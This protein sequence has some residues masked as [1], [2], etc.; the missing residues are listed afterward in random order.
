MKRRASD[1]KGRWAR[2]LGPV[3]FA[4]ALGQA[5]WA[6]D[7]PTWAFEPA[8]D[9]YSD[10]A[11]LD[12]RHL[13]EE[14]AG[15]HG[16]VR[17]TPDGA[18]L[19]RGDGKPLRLW[20]IDSK[21]F[22]THVKRR[23]GEW[24]E[25]Y[26]AETLERHF[27][28]LAKRGINAVRI[29]GDISPTGSQPITEVNAREVEAIQRYVAVAKKHGIYVIL[30]PYW[31]KAKIPDGWEGALPGMYPG[32]RPWG[33]VFFD[34]AFQAAYRGWLRQL[35][36]GPNPHGPVLKDEPAIAV[37]QM[38]NE[39]SPLFPTFDKLPGA[40][41]LAIGRRFHAWAME[42]Y[43]DTEGIRKEWGRAK[44]KGD[45]WEGGV[46]GLYSVRALGSKPSGARRGPERRMRDQLE[47]IGESM[48]A[49]YAE[50]NR[51]LAEDLGCKQLTNGSNW[52]TASVTK[53]ND[54]ERWA[55]AGADVLAVNR[56][57]G[58]TGHIGWTRIKGR[59][60]KTQGWRV[61]PG[62]LVTFDSVLR[63]P[64]RLP[65]NLRHLA[66]T[67]MMI[68][69]SSWKHPARYQSEGPFLVAAYGSL[70]GL[71]AFTW[72]N[73]KVPEWHAD[74]RRKVFPVKEGERGYALDKWSAVVPQIAGAWPANAVIY[75]RGLV[76]E[77]AAVVREER[78][79][80]SLWERLPPPLPE[81]G[82]FDPNRDARPPKDEGLEVGEGQ[83]S[84]LAFLAGRVE[85]S[86][87]D[88]D[89]LEVQGLSDALSTPGRVRSVTGELELDY[90]RGFA[91]MDTPQAQGATGFWRDAG[92]EVALSTVTIRSANEYAAIQ[93]VA[94]DERPLAESRKVLV[95]FASTAR[96]TGWE[97]QGGTF[98]HPKEAEE[99][100][101][102]RIEWTGE[103]PWRI[104][105]AVQ[106][107]LEI[108]NPRL[109]RA[110][111]LDPNGYA[112]RELELAETETKRKLTLPPETMYVLLRD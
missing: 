60:E 54:V 106:T 3:A 98:P 26:S 51:F 1:R 76:R 15:Q 47:F 91:R 9:P 2:A 93:A 80:E 94:L 61:D 45:D 65:T 53:L 27:S 104:A 70:S 108:A 92:G 36:T 17:R 30:S 82:S 107:T 74:P 63:N 58:A 23:G 55:N 42:R 43:G 19:L 48:R 101:G 33:L 13:N 56:Y 52:K 84:P 12:L 57:T 32:D 110:T 37:L 79:L 25:V 96:P 8:E 64:H 81:G 20:A 29:H 90:V 109:A 31:A 72:F 41:K 86:V 16:F 38:F 67:P 100:E 112:V 75:R 102:H 6:E 78:R 77:G 10:E 111:L 11:L 5:T 71:D 40:Q 35:L 39:D 50:T 83:L 66:R 89:E 69:E 46:F 68:T 34:P 59:W 24:K 62:H 28:F 87:G 49:F 14:S 103:P 18:G 105:S 99:I 21:L 95:Q 44:R 7:A 4:L 22:R 85:W 73:A 97:L 88:A